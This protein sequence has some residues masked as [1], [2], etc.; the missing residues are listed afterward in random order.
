[1]SNKIKTVILFITAMVITIPM[2]T[3]V[4]N[5]LTSEERST[6]SNNETS[7]TTNSMPDVHPNNA[8]RL[9]SVTKTTPVTTTVT[10]FTTETTSIAVT[11]TTTAIETTATTVATITPEPQPAV[12]AEPREYRHFDL[13]FWAG[14]SRTVG[15]AACCGI[16]EVSVLAKEGIGLSW[17]QENFESIKDIKGSNIIFNFGVNDLGNV[18][19]YIDFYNNLPDEFLKDNQIFIMSVNPV[20]ENTESQYGYY[21]TNGDI[22]NFNETL[23]NGLREDIYFLDTNSYLKSKGFSTWD[24][25]HYNPNTYQDILNY[26]IETITYTND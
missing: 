4:C 12:T 2:Y 17:C 23:K 14:D 22:D 26:T 25:L 8:I 9:K 6:I 5:G 15:F 24:G 3:I 20:D 18:Y 10:T 13:Y 7:E 11:T 16:N 19:N 21:I 1:M